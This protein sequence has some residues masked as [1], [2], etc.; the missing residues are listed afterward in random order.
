[1]NEIGA[2]GDQSRCDEQIAQLAGLI[3]YDSGA[4][5]AKTN[6]SLFN[7]PGIV[8]KLRFEMANLV[9]VAEMFQSVFDSLGE[10]CLLVR[11]QGASA[12]YGYSE[13]TESRF[14]KN[15]LYIMSD[16]WP[17]NAEHSPL[18]RMAYWVMPTLLGGAMRGKEFLEC[19]I[20]YEGL[21]MA[22]AGYRPG[23]VRFRLMGLLGI[24][25][26]IED[27]LNEE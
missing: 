17:E 14:L 9:V 1:M 24:Q 18:A 23:M 16:K 19:L 4:I 22:S 7:H 6:F 25:L 26:S 15:M 8:Q 13:K 2:N 5:N 20:C 21:L 12:L 27:C 11:E 10:L 3:Y